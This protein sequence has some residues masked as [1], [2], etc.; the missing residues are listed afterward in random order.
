MFASLHSL[1][2]GLLLSG[3][4]CPL[5]IATATCRL[6]ALSICKPI[7]CLPRI[8]YHH[9]MAWHGMPYPTTTQLTIT[10]GVC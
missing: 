4:G 3:H 2:D 9:G 5:T 8:P 1:P 10:N 7:S 6:P